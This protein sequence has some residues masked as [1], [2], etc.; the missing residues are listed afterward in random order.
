MKRWITNKAP[1]YK[2][3][4]NT[5]FEQV[6]RRC[7]TEKERKL[8]GSWITESLIAAFVYLYQQNHAVSF[9]VYD[10]SSHLCGG[11][12]GVL[13]GNMLFAESMF[14]SQTNVSKWLLIQLCKSRLFPIIDCQV[15][16]NHLVSLGAFNISQSKF[17]DLIRLHSKKQKPDPLV[18]EN[19]LT[20]LCRN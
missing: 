19:V 17:Q 12:Y 16:S 20:A 2:L 8:E 10:S 13:L 3:A 11:L 5:N 6:M 1:S 7:G 15:H 4:V 9:E 18:I 14:S